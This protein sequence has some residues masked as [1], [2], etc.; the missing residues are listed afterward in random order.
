VKVLRYD[1]LPD[2]AVPALVGGMLWPG[3]AVLWG[4]SGEGKSFT[5]SALALSVAAGAPFADRRVQQGPVLMLAFEGGVADVRRRLVAGAD[6]LGCD[7]PLPVHVACDPPSLADGRFVSSVRDALAELPGVRML[8]IDTLSAAT[9]G[10]FDLD[11]NRDVERVLALLRT[12]TALTPNLTTVLIHHAGHDRS[13]MRGGSALFAAC[14]TVL[15]CDKGTLADDKQRFAERNVRIPFDLRPHHG[16]LVFMPRQSTEAV[17]V[18]RQEIRALLEAGPATSF[19]SVH[20]VVGG[21]REDVLRTFH[22]VRAE[23]AREPVG[24]VLGTGQKAR[25]GGSHRGSGPGSHV[26]ELAGTG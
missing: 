20:K 11:S 2:V 14:D 12:A 15:R 9:G 22:E 10:A 25:R 8:T 16:S 7:E 13:R 24:T 6:A 19:G 21:R 3:L 17:D 23:I 18:R 4:P 5:A 26:R 1:A